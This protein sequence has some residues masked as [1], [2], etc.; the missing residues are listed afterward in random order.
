[1]GRRALCHFPKLQEMLE[2]NELKD[3]N[4]RIYCSHRGCLTEEM[5]NRFK[6]NLLIPD[7]IINPFLTDSQQVQQTL[8]IDLTDLQNQREAEVLVREVPGVTGTLGKAN[9]HFDPTQTGS[10]T[11]PPR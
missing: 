5:T 8:Q 1:M 10:G 7:W 9:S 6:D 4:V 11:A 3:E 2:K